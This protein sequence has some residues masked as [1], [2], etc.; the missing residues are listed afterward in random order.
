[1]TLRT[2]LGLVIGSVLLLSACVVDRFAGITITNPCS[3]DITV[4]RY[5]GSLG[6]QR[7]E[8]P[9]LSS[10]QIVEAGATIKMAV[11]P[12][13]NRIVIDELGLEDVFELVDIDDRHEVIIPT[14]ACLVDE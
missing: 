5:F 10:V 11:T 7:P 14:S 8:N 4:T 2:R 12:T 9:D 13:A 1:M 3:H 6:S